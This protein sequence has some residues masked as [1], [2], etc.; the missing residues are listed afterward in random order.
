MQKDL[1]VKHGESVENAIIIDAQDAISGVIEKHRHIDL[2]LGTKDNDVKSVEQNLIKE[3]KKI[4]DQFVIK[5]DD[6]TEKILYFEISSFF[7]TI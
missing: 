6:G 3:N 2:I 1:E 4:Y 7:G 5:M